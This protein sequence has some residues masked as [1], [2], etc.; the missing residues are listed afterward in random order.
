M[1]P[2]SD[3]EFNADLYFMSFYAQASSVSDDK[4][5]INPIEIFNVRIAYQL[6]PKLKL[7][8]T[9]YNLLDINWGDTWREGA[10]DV[11]HQG[12]DVD[13]IGRRIMLGVEAAF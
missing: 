7:A 1:T 10:L 9:G 2:H 12:P 5:I 3:W 11:E 8:L 4:I 6:M 13:R